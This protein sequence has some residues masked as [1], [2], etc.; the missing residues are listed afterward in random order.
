M[1]STFSKIKAK[2][3]GRRQLSLGRNPPPRES[4]LLPGPFALI[5]ENVLCIRLRS[6]S[7]GDDHRLSP[8]PPQDPQE[9]WCEAFASRFQ[10]ERYRL[11]PLRFG[12]APTGPEER[13]GAL[14]SPL[15]APTRP[16]DP[17]R[18]Y[19][20]KLHKFNRALDID[21]CLHRSQGPGLD[22]AP[23]SFR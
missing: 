19:M 15:R 17:T 8:L 9:P 11:P 4:C 22:P 6:G 3:P 18:A 1:Q 21:S 14:I 10:R 5:F 2:G 23:T 20:S 16:A 12:A 7:S 13:A